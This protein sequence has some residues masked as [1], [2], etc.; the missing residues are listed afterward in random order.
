MVMTVRFLVGPVPL[1]PPCNSSTRPPSPWD[2]DWTDFW[3]DVTD[4]RQAREETRARIRSEL[5]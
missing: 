4:A 1:P 3:G 2:F 5:E